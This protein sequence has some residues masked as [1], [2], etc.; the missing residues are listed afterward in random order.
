MGEEADRF[1]IR[2]RECRN[3]AAQTPDREWRDKLIDIARDL[4]LEAD[5]LDEEEAARRNE[6]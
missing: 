5:R 6:E 3:Q 1:R 2:S 4:E